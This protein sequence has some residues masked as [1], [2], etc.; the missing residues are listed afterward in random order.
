MPFFLQFRCHFCQ[1]KKKRGGNRANVSTQRCRS[2]PSPPLKLNGTD[3]APTAAKEKD[4]DIDR[5]GFPRGPLAQR[6]EVVTVMPP[7]QKGGQNGSE[8]E[9]K[10]KAKTRGLLPLAS[11]RWGRTQQPRKTIAQPDSAIPGMPPRSEGGD[12]ERGTWQE[13]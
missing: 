11:S 7:S 1:K 4:L 9:K 3:L 6:L 2:T 5:A 8:N 12:K 10:M 13:Q